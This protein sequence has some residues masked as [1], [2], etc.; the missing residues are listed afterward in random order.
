MN[1]KKNSKEDRFLLV[2]L[3]T[4]ADKDSVWRNAN[5]PGF[6]SLTQGIPKI[7]TPLFRRFGVRPTYLLSYEVLED[8][9]SCD[10]LSELGTT[11]E[12]GAHLHTEFVPP[13]RS[14]FLHNMGGLPNYEIQAQ[15]SPDIEEEKLSN[16]TDL[17]RESF[18]Y[19][20][21][22]FRSGRYGMSNVTPSILAK[23]GY[24][25]DSS[26]TPGLRWN[27]PEGKIDYRQAQR[28]PHWLYTPNGK[29]LELPVSIMPGGKV[30]HLVRDL[31]DI[32]SRIA[33]RLLGKRSQYHW[34][35]P[36]WCSGMDLI[37]YIERS[38]DQFLVMMLHSME[39]IPG[40]SPYAKT[41][42]DVKRIILAMEQC[43]EYAQR[44]G[45][46][47]CTMAEAAQMIKS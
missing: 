36:S 26:I 19:A 34:L 18:G 7:L 40:A 46:V 9:V 3:D 23:L 1:Y 29:L 30:A 32:P 35:R 4:E 15:L 16:L 41:A 2:T 24:L 22:S 42:D 27:Y 33:R 8:K 6:R 10:V 14:L 12:L 17:F 45:I 20:P 21:V 38:N 13:D 44:N 11:A 28:E 5:P 25:V 31:P 37:R 43:F 39:V 47:F